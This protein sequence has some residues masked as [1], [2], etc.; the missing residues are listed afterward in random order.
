ANATLYLKPPR[1]RVGVVPPAATSRRSTA[2]SGW[3]SLVATVRRADPAARYRVPRAAIRR[4]AACSAAALSTECRTV[5][6]TSDGSA[7][8]ATAAVGQRTDDFRAPGW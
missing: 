7:R 6:A 2:R 3:R 5:S 8:P 4:A 1:A